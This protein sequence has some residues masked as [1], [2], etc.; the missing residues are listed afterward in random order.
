MSD[1]PTRES[2]LPEEEVLDVEDIQGNILPGFNKDHLTL[3][4]FCITDV[5]STRSWLRELAPNVATTREVLDDRRLRRMIKARRGF[6]P[7]G[8]IA[9]WINLGLSAE[10]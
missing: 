10:A 1:D 6:E 5:S 9:T 2:N 4:F 3:L 8:M 7:D